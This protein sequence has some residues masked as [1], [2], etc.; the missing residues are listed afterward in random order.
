VNRTRR[1]SKSAEHIANIAE[2]VKPKSGV[3]PHKKIFF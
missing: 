2:K 3:Q 1:G